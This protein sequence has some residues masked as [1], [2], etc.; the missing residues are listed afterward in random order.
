[1]ATIIQPRI[2]ER[3]GRRANDGNVFGIAALAALAGLSSAA[4]IGWGTGFW[5]VAVL[6]AGAMLASTAIALT[7]NLFRRGRRMTAQ[8]MDRGA[9]TAAIN[10]ASEPLMSRI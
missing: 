5:E 9:L 10:T 6:F 8:A 3:R 1:M 4:V 2:T 7:V